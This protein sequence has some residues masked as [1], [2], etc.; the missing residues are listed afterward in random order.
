MDKE[1]KTFT[2]VEA[3]AIDS[4]PRASVLKEQVLKIL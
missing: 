2:P 4:D 1:L 3:D